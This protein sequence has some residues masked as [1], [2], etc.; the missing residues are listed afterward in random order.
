MYTL[1]MVTYDN[2]NKNHYTLLD[3]ELRVVCRTDGGGRVRMVVEGE[4]QYVVCDADKDF[5][6]QIYPSD[7]LLLNV[8]AKKPTI[9]CGRSR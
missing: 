2:G 6:G 9:K 1:V 4:Y 7:E 3:D 8:A 5:G